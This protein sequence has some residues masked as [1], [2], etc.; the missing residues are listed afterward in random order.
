MGVWFA[1]HCLMG[2]QERV[3]LAGN[4]CL[5]FSL[6]SPFA[7]W[8]VKPCNPR[9]WRHQNPRILVLKD[10]RRIGSSLL[11]LLRRKRQM[12]RDLGLRSREL[13]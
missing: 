1:H 3:P 6:P 8:Y 7:P 2:I 4:P 13:G 12:P 11:T 9:I 5:L 10:P